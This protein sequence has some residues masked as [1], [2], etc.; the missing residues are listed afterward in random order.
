MEGRGQDCSGKMLRS[1]LLS[2]SL[3]L[4]LK[5][6]A[7]L[8]PRPLFWAGLAGMAALQWQPVERVLPIPQL[9]TRVVGLSSGPRAGRRWLGRRR[10][11]APALW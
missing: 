4:Q 2:L 6:G 8:L 3:S 11:A 9:W 5:N 1:F 7:G 10:L